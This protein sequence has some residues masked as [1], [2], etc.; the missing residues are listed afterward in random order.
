MKSL[1][2]IF[3]GALPQHTDGE[4]AGSGEHGREE[5]SSYLLLGQKRGSPEKNAVQ[6]SRQEVLNYLG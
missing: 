6:P 4:S 3:R 1:G 2:D 5:E